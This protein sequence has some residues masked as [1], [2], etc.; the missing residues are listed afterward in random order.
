MESEIQK[1]EQ[2]LDGLSWTFIEDARKYTLMIRCC[3][4]VVTRLKSS[5]KGK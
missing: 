1:R 5:A 3:V 4:F 2:H